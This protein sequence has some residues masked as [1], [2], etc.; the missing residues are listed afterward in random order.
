MAEQAGE[1]LEL[2]K[3]DPTR[4]SSPDKSPGDEAS[5]PDVDDES[6]D[7]TEDGYASDGGRAG[8]QHEMVNMESVD[9]DDG[10]PSGSQTAQE[11]RIDSDF[12]RADRH[13]N[14]CQV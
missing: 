13:I 5:D 9:N 3:L 11:G 6:E 7:D 12:G 2:L 14:L 8:A 4:S 10:Q 1:R